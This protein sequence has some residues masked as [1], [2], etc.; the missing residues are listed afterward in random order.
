MDGRDRDKQCVMGQLHSPRPSIQQLT[1]YQY[2]I[3]SHTCRGTLSTRL[4]VIVTHS[5]LGTL[6]VETALV[7]KIN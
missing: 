5:T 2:P 6:F 3:A 4:T 1:R 7:A